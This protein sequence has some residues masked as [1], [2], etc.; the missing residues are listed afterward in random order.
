VA[1]FPVNGPQVPVFGFGET[2]S[3]GQF[4][5]ENYLGGHR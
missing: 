4:I 5:M 1:D 3:L 2:E